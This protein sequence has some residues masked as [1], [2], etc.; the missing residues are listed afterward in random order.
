MLKASLA[1]CAIVVLVGCGDENKQARQKQGRVGGL[2]TAD[3]PIIVSD[4]SPA[5]L[6]HKGTGDRDFHIV[7]D[8][9]KSTAS[10][11]NFTAYSLECDGFKVSCST[12]LNSGWEL[13]TFDDS[14]S[15]GMAITAPDPQ[16]VQAVIYENDLDTIVDNTT[17]ETVGGTAL[18]SPNHTLVSVTLANPSTKS[19]FSCSKGTNP[20][21]V[22]IRRK[23]TGM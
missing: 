19:T 23:G 6:K 3:S 21:K 12:S 15:M 5:H 1:L 20:C 18:I 7:G 10:V 13:D 22:K 14:N 9:T 16:T 11:K 2:T 4:G 8:G 17:D